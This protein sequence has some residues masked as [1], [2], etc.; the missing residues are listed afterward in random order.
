MVGD[1][2]Y[3]DMFNRLPF[4]RADTYQEFRD[5]YLAAF[6]SPNI[7][8][9]MQRLPTYMIL[10]DHEIEDNWS[11]DRLR[12]S[13]RYQLFRKF[14]VTSGVFVPNPMSARTYHARRNPEALAN[15]D[16][17]AGFPGTRAAILRKIVE[18]GIQNVVFL[19]GD[20]HCC[21]VAE[22]FVT[23][24]PEAERIRSFSVTSSAFYWPFPFA[25]GE[26]SDFVH[27]SRATG[28]EDTFRFE[29]TEGRELNMD[30]RARNF[31]QE[32]NFTHL[33]VDP[34]THAL[35]VRVYDKRGRIV[36]EE[37]GAGRSVPL[38][39]KLGLEPW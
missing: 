19:S 12:R 10:D 17:W 29:D 38:D 28:Q 35:R 24:T 33:T 26:P 5:R 36:V 31:S 3:A 22:I 2:I 27:D 16:T 25:D 18:A 8:R 39:A 15:S 20:I 37:D 11:Q 4:G 34:A 13:A 1:Q 30:Y 6:G 9:L 32:D 21:N 23:G 7:R 14:I